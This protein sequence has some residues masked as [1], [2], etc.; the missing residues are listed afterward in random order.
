[1]TH[2]RRIYYSAIQKAEIWDW[3][4][5]GETLHSIGRLFDRG[6]SSIFSVLE[7]TGGIRPTDRKRPVRAL[8]LTER[9]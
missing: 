9:E 1:M 5:R 7:P 8:T 6:H 4:K 3:W 2:R